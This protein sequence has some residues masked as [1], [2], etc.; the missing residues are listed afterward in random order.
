MKRSTKILLAFYGFIVLS[1][2]LFMWFRPLTDLY[3]SYVFRPFSGLWMRFSDLFPFSLGE[4]F[5]VIALVAIVVGFA[6]STGLLFVKKIRF[7]GFRI[8]GKILAWL[9]MI[10]LWLLNFHWLALYR[11]TPTLEKYLTVS[12]RSDEVF[13]SL[14]EE[15]V[16][17]IVELE[18]RIQRDTN[19]YFKFSTDYETDIPDA[20]RALAD[21]FPEFSGYY[22]DT[23]R[24]SFSFFMSQS[25]TSG[26]Y[27]PMFEEANV[28]AHLVDAQY[29]CVIC[30]E[31]THTRGI[32]LEDEAN[33]FGIL[34]AINS[35]NPDIR[36]SGYL[37]MMEYLSLQTDQ[38]G[39]EAESRLENANDLLQSTMWNDMYRYYEETYWE[40]HEDD[41]IIPTAV[42][43]DLQNTVYD[44]TLVLQ[45][46]K[47]GKK[48][49]DRVVEA[50]L[51]YYAEHGTLSIVKK[52]TK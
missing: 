40:D 45:G 24:I 9:C 25:G 10:V 14:Y 7:R 19:G 8:Y 39:G 22:P 15:A 30:H 50:L 51:D 44:T 48:S 42:V 17:S 20:M 5:I 41:V 28:N 23:K 2:L 52:E 43:N 46:V 31:L 49:Y 3:V 33:F 27:L 47:D 11:A 4:W 21:A 35:E 13:V 12:D 36:Y 37:I 18:P 16:R 26:I 6:V 1:Y 38:F 29:P 32:I 34:A